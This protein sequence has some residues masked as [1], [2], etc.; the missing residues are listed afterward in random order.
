MLFEEI[1]A[2]YPDNPMKHENTLLVK[3]SPV[4]MLKQAVHIVATVLWRAAKPLLLHSQLS[5]ASDS[6]QAY[7]KFPRSMIPTWRGA[8]IILLNNAITRSKRTN[9]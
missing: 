7:F 5:K 8:S 3:R 2:T 9:E 1:I 6:T 4:W